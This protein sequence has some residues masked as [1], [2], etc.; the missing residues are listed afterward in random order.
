[1]L[2]AERSLEPVYSRLPSLLAAPPALPDDSPP[3]PSLEASRSCVR[4]VVCV[5]AEPTESGVVF[6]V[7]NLQ[8]NPLAVTITAQLAGLE[9]KVALPHTR[10]YPSGTHRAFVARRSPSASQ[11]SYRFRFTYRP[12]FATSRT[13]HDEHFCV[14]REQRMDSLWFYVENAHPAPISVRFDLAPQNLRLDTRSPHVG[15][16][17]N[18]QRTL[19]FRGVIPNGSATWDASYT[20]RWAFG[21]AVGD[22]DRAH[23]YALPFQRGTTRTLVQGYN[24][25]FSHH[26][27]FALDFDLPRNTKVTAVRDGIVVATE[28]RYGDGKAEA[29]YRNRANYVHVLHADGTLAQYV[30]LERN[31]VAVRVGQRVERG[32]VLGYSGTSGYS[33]GPH[34]HF[35]IVRLTPALTYESIP[36][37]FRIDGEAIAELQEGAAYTAH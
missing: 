33:A 15:V 29:A 27:S 7:D 16:Y 9:A 25:R 26:G 31:R 4:D 36:V 19:A 35:E 1:M 8:K 22:P 30:H 3:G 28:S 24:G 5:Q 32:Q 14:V 21:D 17:P 12:A 13:C 20:T 18:G 6:V 2:L 23:V 34:L 10:V 37:R 11:W